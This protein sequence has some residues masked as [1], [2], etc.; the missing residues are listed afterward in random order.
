[1]IK[2]VT[3][4]SVE[5]KGLV[6]FS[7]VLSGHH[8]PSQSEVGVGIQGRGYRGTLLF[9]FSPWVVLPVF[10]FNPGPPTQA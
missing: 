10:S 6:L 8:P 2:D 3:S 7:L 4:N 1:M 5:R 9:V